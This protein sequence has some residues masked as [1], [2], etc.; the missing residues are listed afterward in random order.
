[1]GELYNNIMIYNVKILIGVEVLEGFNVT[2]MCKYITSSRIKWGHTD[3]LF[4][5]PLY[6]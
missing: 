1:M 5:H 4:V 6:S 2:N 3:A